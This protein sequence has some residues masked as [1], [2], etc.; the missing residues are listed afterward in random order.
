MKINQKLAAGLSVLLN[1]SSAFAMEGVDRDNLPASFIPKLKPKCD[2]VIPNPPFEVAE[3]CRTDP[4]ILTQWREKLNDT[5]NFAIVHGIG[6]DSQKR[7]LSCFYEGVESLTAEELYLSTPHVVLNL[8]SI[9]SGTLVDTHNI[10]TWYSTGL[11]LDVPVS[12]IWGAHTHDAY[13]P[14]EIAEKFNQVKFRNDISDGTRPSQG[15]CDPKSFVPGTLAG[16][17]NE[18]A[19]YSAVEGS[20]AKI[21]IRGVFISRS[22]SYATSTEKRISRKGEIALAQKLAEQLNVPFYDWRKNT[23]PIV[24]PNTSDSEEE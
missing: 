7:L 3:D 20:E 4:S 6:M 24:D 9:V 15:I 11:I 16:V 22:G 13:A 21:S 19:F 8:R 23:N 18:V 17:A 1:F 14:M 10:R 5:E 2:V 12:H